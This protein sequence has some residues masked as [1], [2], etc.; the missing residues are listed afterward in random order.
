MQPFNIAESSLFHS[1]IL[2]LLVGRAEQVKVTK[3][4]ELLW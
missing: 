2:G 4:P 3:T 1:N